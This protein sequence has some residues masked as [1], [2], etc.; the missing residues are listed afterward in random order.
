MSADAGTTLQGG[1]RSA[2]EN[3]PKARQTLANGHLEPVKTA[4]KRRKAVVRGV[5]LGGKEWDFWFGKDGVCV[6]RK[7][8]R[9]EETRLVP[10][11]AVATGAGLEVEVG[12]RVF[13]AALRK[14]GLAFCEVRNRAR[15][16]LL[17]WRRVALLDAADDSAVQPSLFKELA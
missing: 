14:E 4:S 3:T 12:G 11:S 6:H 16:K 15:T 10:F 7:H 2:T 13:R 17:P 5:R 1:S 8:A 9:A